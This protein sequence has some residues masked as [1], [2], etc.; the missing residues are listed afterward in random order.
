MT[1]LGF[2]KTCNACGFGEIEID[3]IYVLKT[4]NPFLDAY[5]VK[6]LDKKNG[7][8]QYK[9][10]KSDFITSTHEKTFKELYVKL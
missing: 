10:I 6:V 4:D 1:L 7:Y 8:V 3:E 2:A 9:F 5:T